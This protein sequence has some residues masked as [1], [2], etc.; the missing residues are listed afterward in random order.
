MICNL[1]DATFGHDVCSTAW[2]TPAHLQ[3]VRGREQFDGVTL[4]TDG[5]I[6]DGTAGRVDSRVKLGWLHEPPELIPGVYR[7]AALVVDDFERILT[8]HPALLDLAGF[9]FMPY[10]GV[11][12][13]RADWGL[14]PKRHLCSML[15]GHKQATSGHRLRQTIADQLP[16]TVTMFGSRGT[17]TD[18]SIAT[19]LRVNREFAFTV[20]TETQ[21]LDN[22]FTEWLLDCFAV[23]TVPVFW[24]CPNVGRYFNAAGILS[25]ETPAQCA[26]IVRGLSWELYESLLPA[27]ADNLARV[28]D[29]AV[30]EDWM[31]TNVLRRYE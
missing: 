29:Y 4:F 17:S 25:F 11:W 3:Y 16:P 24:G 6:V 31:H 23:G 28:A 26:E 13:E 22:L 19:K 21:R 10:A 8:Y 27:V 9:E 1:F 12:I 20:V 2:K 14:H 15:I 7:R 30:A 18:Y 5:F